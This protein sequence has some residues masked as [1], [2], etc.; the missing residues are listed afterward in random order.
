MLDT[1]IMRHVMKIPLWEP[2]MPETMYTVMMLHSHSVM[3]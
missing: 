2:E 3:D 1:N